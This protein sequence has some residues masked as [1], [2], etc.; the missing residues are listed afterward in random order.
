MTILLLF[1]EIS[2]AIPSHSNRNLCDRE[3]CVNAKMFLTQILL[4]FK[5]VRGIC[6]VHNRK[7]LAL[8]VTSV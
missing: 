5:F 3:F 4:M 1:T 8:K 6:H 7:M 2:Q